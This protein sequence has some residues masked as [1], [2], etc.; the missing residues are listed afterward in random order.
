VTAHLLILASASKSRAAVLAAAGVAFSQIPAD[1]DEASVKTEMQARGQTA[2]AC[3]AKLAEMKALAV[4]A[5]HPSAY[6]IGCDQMLGC[7]GRWFDKPAD[8]SAARE[9][10]RALRGRT[11]MLF[12][13]MVVT[14]ADKTVWRTADQA[15]LTMRDFSDDFL[16]AYLAQVGGQVLWSVGGYQ[17][18]G[19]G[20]QLFSAVRGDFFSILGLPLLPL[21]AFLRDHGLIKT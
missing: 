8:M 6:V 13:G 14:R 3:A 12:N 16:D 10:L 15:E 5:R 7:D 19:P 18:E 21:L 11:H 17:L 4:S 20:A 2:A 9:Q 1:V